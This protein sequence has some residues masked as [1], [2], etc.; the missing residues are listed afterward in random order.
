MATG[1]TVVIMNIISLIIVIIGIRIIIGMLKTMCGILNKIP[2]IGTFN[3]ILGMLVSGC[4]CIVLMF[5]IVAVMLLPPS[6][7]SEL[8]TKMCLEIDE[9]VI[10]SRAM[11]YNIFI[12][13]KSLSKN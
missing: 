10:V 12:S 13:Y 8:S 7:K 5:V 1:I 6:N 3:K 11:D 4:S 2:I 9:S